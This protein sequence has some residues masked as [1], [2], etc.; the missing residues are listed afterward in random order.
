MASL[1]TVEVP[2]RGMDCADCT[3]HVQHAIANLPG[4][5]SVEVFL[6]SEKAVVRLD[7]R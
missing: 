2:I 3:R 1:K 6:A 4:V 7:A 5:E